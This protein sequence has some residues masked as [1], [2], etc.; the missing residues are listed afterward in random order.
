MSTNDGVTLRRFLDHAHRLLNCMEE[1]LGSS[2]ESVEI[3]F[4]CSNNFGPGNLTDSE[5]RHLLELLP[6][7]VPN[8]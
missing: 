2:G 6:K 5:P 3:P 1:L 7:I 4:E 8:V